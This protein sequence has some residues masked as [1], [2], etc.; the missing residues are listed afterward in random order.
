M[1]RFALRRLKFASRRSSHC[2]E[3]S[4]EGAVLAPPLLLW[5]GGYPVAARLRLLD[6]PAGGVSGN[7]AAIISR[8]TTRLRTARQ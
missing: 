3:A 4:K 5:D 7:S 6:Y 8:L 1:P 2:R